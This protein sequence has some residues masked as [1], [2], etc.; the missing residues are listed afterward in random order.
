MSEIV[1]KRFE[2]A[3][4]KVKQ[5]QQEFQNELKEK[6]GAIR[7]RTIEELRKVVG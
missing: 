3:Q 6:I 7:K 1:K 4:N 5:K 2:V